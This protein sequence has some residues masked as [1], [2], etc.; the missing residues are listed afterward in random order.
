MIRVL[1]LLG[2]ALPVFAQDFPSK[3]I[4]LVVPAAPGG[5]TDLLARRAAGYFENLSLIHI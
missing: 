2:L 1:M 3:P 4:R 5:L